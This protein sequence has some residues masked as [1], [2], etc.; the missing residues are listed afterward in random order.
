MQYAVFCKMTG[1]VVVSGGRDAVAGAGDLASLTTAGF[2]VPNRDDPNLIRRQ[3]SEERL[4]EFHDSRRI[5]VIDDVAATVNRIADSLTPLYN[6]V[7]RETDPREALRR[8]KTAQAEGAPYDALVVDLFMPGMLGSELIRQLGSPPPAIVINTASM[9]A[10]VVAAI[11]VQIDSFTS[12][13]SEALFDAY[14]GAR[15][16]LGL[17]AVAVLS[18]HK[19]EDLKSLVDEIDSAML[20]RSYAAD[21]SAEFL[22]GYNPPLKEINFTQE[23]V[24]RFCEDLHI[25]VV[26]ME[27]ILLKLAQADFFRS[28]W[29]NENGGAF[30]AAMTRLKSARYSNTFAETP[31]LTAANLHHLVG[32]LFLAGPPALEDA[33]GSAGAGA[34]RQWR[35][36]WS[37]AGEKL[38]PGYKAFERHLR[39][40][41]D[42]EELV[43]SLCPECELSQNEP[44]SAEKFKKVPVIDPEHFLPPFI[45]AVLNAHR[46]RVGSYDQPGTDVLLMFHSEEEQYRRHTPEELVRRFHDIQC[47]DYYCLSL[48]DLVERPLDAD[49]QT[50]LP[51]M[52]MFQRSGQG[53]FEVFQDEYG[54]ELNIY[55]KL[56]EKTRDFLAA[57]AR[58]KE[59]AAKKPDGTWMLDPCLGIE[60]PVSEDL[61]PEGDIVVLGS[62]P[63][64]LETGAKPMLYQAEGLRIF[65]SEEPYN[66]HMSAS[67]VIKEFLREYLSR[68]NDPRA[69]CYDTEKL[70]E[71]YHDGI[72]L[73]VEGS[74]M[75]VDMRPDTSHW[76]Y[77][78]LRELGLKKS[79]IKFDRE[80]FRSR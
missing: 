51:E 74:T 79:K 70:R 12:R 6:R 54:T 48:H 4:K 77:K 5:L 41:V 14:R 43:R 19:L 64:N 27:P 66:A 44:D 35:E 25:F 62:R 68:K 56:S 2:G 29:W 52:A 49:F 26:A 9:M 80:S 76:A 24:H 45:S 47:G 30:T 34:I 58:K 50:V 20:I 57:I 22:A 78:T 69:S 53:F 32:Q 39:G 37:A 18:H 28:S 63:A 15:E 40:E 36:A 33:A 1:A 38:N 72:R 13:N 46:A 75:L 61:G 11:R 16:R 23:T 60:I 65:A 21:D 10:P 8:I 55:I 7:E 59:R 73:E 3:L 17:P 42:L 67:G 71:I 31:G